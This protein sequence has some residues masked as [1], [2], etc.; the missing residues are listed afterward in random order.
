MPQIG[1]FGHHLSLKSSSS[2][3]QAMKVHGCPKLVKEVT[4]IPIKIPAGLFKMEFDLQT[5]KC[6]R[7]VRNFEKES[8]WV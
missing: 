8:S 4:R 2:C 1:P 5:T 3:F 7:T 6:A